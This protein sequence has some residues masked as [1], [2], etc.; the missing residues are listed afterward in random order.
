MS[1]FD[2]LLGDPVAAKVIGLAGAALGRV[3]RGSRGRASLAGVARG[4]RR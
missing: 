1:E 4:P 2:N 3:V